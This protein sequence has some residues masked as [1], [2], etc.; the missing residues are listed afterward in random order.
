MEKALKALLDDLEENDDE[1][2]APDSGQATI[3]PDVED[4]NTTKV[5]DSSACRK[6]LQSES[7][8]QQL[9]RAIGCPE[10]ASIELEGVEVSCKVS[11]SLEELFIDVQFN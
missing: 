2:Q 11:D 10:N 4:P 6:V 9:F 7:T 3:T 1:V 5:L 8:V